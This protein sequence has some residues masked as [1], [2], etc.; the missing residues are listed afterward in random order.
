MKAK[1]LGAL[2]ITLLSGVALA[3]TGGAGGGA[4]GAGGAGTGGTGHGGPAG[5]AP[6]MTGGTGSGADG[7]TGSGTGTG[8]SGDAG[9]GMNGGNGSTMGGTGAS[10]TE[11]VPGRRARPMAASTRVAAERAGPTTARRDGHARAAA[12]RPP[13]ATVLS[14]RSRQRPWDAP[15]SRPTRPPARNRRSSAPRRFWRRRRADP[16]GCGL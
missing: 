13:P 1:L 4:A 3:Q 6:G 2:A 11:R 8:M 14:G 9:S 12:R 7:T 5:G 15:R 16:S 10:G